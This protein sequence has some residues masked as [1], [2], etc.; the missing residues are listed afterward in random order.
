M[1][2]ELASR[3]EDWC[4]LFTPNP[5]LLLMYKQIDTF[6]VEDY[7]TLFGILL[8][9]IDDTQHAGDYHNKDALS[10]GNL[11]LVCSFFTVHGK[12]KN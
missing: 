2:Q 5:R 4:G 11:Q 1:L 10:V 3:P 8:I 9:W 12:F 6:Q 7:D